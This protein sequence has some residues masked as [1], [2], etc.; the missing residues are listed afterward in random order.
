VTY[1]PAVKIAEQALEHLGQAGP[2]NT[3]VSNGMRRWTREL[4]LPDIGTDS[5]SEAV[6][7]AQNGH[8]GWRYHDGTD[9]IAVGNFG[10]WTHTALG[11]TEKEHVTVVTDIRGALWR[12]VG[13]GT[14][15]GKV[16]RQPQSGGFNPRTVL[17][18]YLIAPTETVAQQAPKPTVKPAA[19]PT[20]AA[21]ASGD[22]YVVR[23]GDT[24]IKIAGKH[25]TTWQ[26]ILAANPP[27]GGKSQDFHI[28][29]ANL[30]TV[31]QKIRIP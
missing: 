24:L 1:V 7:L 13:S 2:L 23:R 3:C 19:K 12:G 18:G 16:A 20:N 30:I 5:V 29:R 22:V 6:R 25:G 9:G 31:G 14:P 17:R 26:R 15:S 10:V 28:L 8:A 27:K 11:S 4:G 21:A